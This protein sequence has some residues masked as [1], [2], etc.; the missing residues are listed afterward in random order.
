[1]LTLFEEHNRLYQNSFLDTASTR[2]R[3][4]SICI[5]FD[6]GLND[7]GSTPDKDRDFSSGLYVQTGSGG[8]PAFCTLGPGGKARPRRDADHSPPS[9]V[10]V[11]NE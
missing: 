5:V 3:G 10:E 7:R 2:S 8:R 11:E 1:M 6:Y 9:S 4:S